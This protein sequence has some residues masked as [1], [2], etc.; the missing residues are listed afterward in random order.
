MN[1]TTVGIP[2]TFQ[3]NCL[4]FRPMCKII[5]TNFN[6]LI[7]LLHFLT[8]WFLVLTEKQNL[9]ILLSRGAGKNM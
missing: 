3:T 2:A 8:I 5:T 1:E 4:Y 7:A 9:T 6:Y